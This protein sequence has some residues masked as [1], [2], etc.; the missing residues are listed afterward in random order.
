M[1]YR[2]FLYRTSAAGSGA[3]ANNTVNR[4]LRY[5]FPDWDKG[6]MPEDHMLSF[7]ASRIKELIQNELG[8][9]S[10]KDCTIE[11]KYS[12]TKKIE[13]LCIEP[14][15]TMV[16]HIW[17]T[18]VK[19]ALQ[20]ELVLLDAQTNKCEYESLTHRF[21]WRNLTVRILELNEQIKKNTVAI[22]QLRR[23]YKESIDHFPEAAYVLT[24]NKCKELDLSE[25]IKAFCKLLSSLL[26]KSE[27]LVCED[28]CFVV[29]GPWYS[30]S[31]TIEAYHKNPN[32]ICYIRNGYVHVDILHRISCEKAFIWIKQNPGKEHHETYSRIIERVFFSEMVQKYP[33]PA[34]RFCAS[35]NITKALRKEKMAVDYS[36]F[37]YFGAEI[38]FHRVPNAFCLMPE[39]CCR[40]TISALKLGEELASFILPFVEE[41]YPYFYDRY[42]LTDNH[43]PAAMLRKITDRL[44]EMRTVLY[45]GEGLE[46]LEPYLE[47]R[48]NFNALDKSNEFNPWGNDPATLKK[49]IHDQRLNIAHVYDIFIQ[50]AEAQ[51]EHGDEDDLFNITGP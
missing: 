3:I 8:A 5:N 48:A 37:Q 32:R 42:Y 2:L 46:V 9:D 28:E 12:P 51:L 10:M 40:K 27:K 38:M 34:D 41:Q 1:K 4:N 30:I 21:S 14:S 17:P 22:W 31:Y 50:W 7:D 47:K 39:N 35:L 23:L 33:N 29:K 45:S 13:Y 26:I 15:Y 36:S 43:I 11:I 18:M 44:I 16:D 25:R 49:L 6:N 24:L 19:I 20:E